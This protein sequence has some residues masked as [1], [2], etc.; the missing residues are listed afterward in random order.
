[1]KKIVRLTEADLARIVKR[2]IKEQQYNDDDM[3][4][5]EGFVNHL[6][7]NRDQMD[8]IKHMTNEAFHVEGADKRTAN[9]LLKNFLK[10]S[11]GK[12]RFISFQNCEGIDFSNVDFCQYPDLVFI[13]LSGTPNNF[14]ETQ[15]NCYEKIWED[16]YEFNK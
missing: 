16:R 11:K 4:E 7:N 9:R 10:G 6:V 5:L 15:D 3:D 14:E 1:M 2:V 8:V 13:N 12:A